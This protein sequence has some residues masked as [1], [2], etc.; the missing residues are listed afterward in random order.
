[1]TKAS[2]QE[3]DQTPVSTQQIRALIYKGNMNQ[4]K[5]KNIQSCYNTRGFLIP[6]LYQWA[7][8]LYK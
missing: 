3:E 5:W 8:H 2:I 6:C 4:Y 1:M 7:D